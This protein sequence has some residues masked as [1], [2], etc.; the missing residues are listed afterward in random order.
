MRALHACHHQEPFFVVMADI[1]SMQ[2]S[3]AKIW[4]SPA[5]L[6]ARN[7]AAVSLSF[8][9]LSGSWFVYFVRVV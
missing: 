9:L 8:F 2:L 3:V 7:D 1:W 5:V 6:S 4:A